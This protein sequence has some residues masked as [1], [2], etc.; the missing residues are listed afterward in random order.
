M[1]AITTESLSASWSFLGN[2][3]LDM[4]CLSSCMPLGGLFPCPLAALVQFAK[5]NFPF[6]Q[7]NTYGIVL[8]LLN[9]TSAIASWSSISVS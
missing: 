7:V 9:G 8:G 5:G 6:P 2:K 4:S 1:D 3:V